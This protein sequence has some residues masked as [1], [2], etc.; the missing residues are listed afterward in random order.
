MGYKYT[1]FWLDEERCEKFR[2]ELNDIADRLMEMN[3][4]EVAPGGPEWMHNDL[5]ETVETLKKI[6]RILDFEN[7]KN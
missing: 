3:E 1:M 2:Q 7:F 5:N 6:S 4:K